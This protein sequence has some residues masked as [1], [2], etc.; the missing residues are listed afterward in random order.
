MKTIKAIIKSVLI[1]ALLLLPFL[2]IS[3]GAT[4]MLKELESR[5]SKLGILALEADGNG[6]TYFL[7]FASGKKYYT[8]QVSAETGQAFADG[9]AWLGMT[10]DD[11]DLIPTAGTAYTADKGEIPDS[12]Y[13]ELSPFDQGLYNTC[14]SVTIARIATD[15]TGVQ[16]SPMQLHTEMGGELLGLSMFQTL[17]YAEEVGLVE[18]RYNPYDDDPWTLEMDRLTPQEVNATRY[19]IRSET[20]AGWYTGT[21]SQVVALKR[22]VLRYDHLAARVDTIKNWDDGAVYPEGREYTANHVF[23]ISGWDEDGWIIH[24]SYGEG[25]G[26][27]R[28][29]YPLLWVFGYEML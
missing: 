7:H 28:F 5:T 3:V 25:P 16:L 20:V 29:D 24:N 23:T 27:L 21:E 26:T 12:Y 11:L 19:R 6:Q 2:A 13:N 10:G 18:E 4:T 1:S 17:D 14:V 22:G 9:D 8:G 15:L